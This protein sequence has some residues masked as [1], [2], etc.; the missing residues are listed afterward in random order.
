MDG[1]IYFWT[2]AKHDPHLPATPSRVHSEAGSRYSRMA[3]NGGPTRSGRRD[4]GK[5]VL[6]EGV[7]TPHVLRWGFALRVAFLYNQSAS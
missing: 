2:A 7:D 1:R 3:E 5:S 4:T 6:L